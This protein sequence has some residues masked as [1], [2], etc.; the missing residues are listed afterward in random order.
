MNN[1]LK[2]YGHE[3]LGSVETP[4]SDEALQYL[5]NLLMKRIKEL[6][7][8]NNFLRIFLIFL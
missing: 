8:V 1:N 2:D 5:K 4:N 3:L 7:K 6:S